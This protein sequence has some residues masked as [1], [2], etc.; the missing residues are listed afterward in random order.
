MSN[1]T[2]VFMSALIQTVAETIGGAPDGVCYAGLMGAGC[3]FDEYQT[4]RSAL[5]SNGLVTLSN[6]V[7]TVTP[8]GIVL[9]DRLTAIL[10]EA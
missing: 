1:R 5:V 2:M 3:T 10:N 8:A 4:I 7:L 9:A 6:N